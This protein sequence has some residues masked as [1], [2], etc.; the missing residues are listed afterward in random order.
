MF[1]VY[2]WN[3]AQTFKQQKRIQ[4]MTKKATAKDVN[5]YIINIIIL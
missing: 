5:A 1:Y 2:A 4:S 3:R